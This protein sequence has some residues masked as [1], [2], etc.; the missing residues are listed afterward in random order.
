[1][2]KNKHQCQELWCIRLANSQAAL[3]AHKYEDVVNHSTECLD[4]L[5]ARLVLP[6]LSLRSVANEKR[7][8]LSKALEDAMQMI[9]CVPTSASGYLRAGS[10]HMTNGKPG[11]AADNFKQGLETVPKSHP[12]YNLLQYENGVAALR[13]RSRFDI[14]GKLP[15]ELLHKILVNAETE[16]VWTY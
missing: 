15:L 1:M 4:E 16:T 3:Y 8:L 9:Q 7:G 14:I 10:I 2:P 11:L 5:M 13:S 6:A 12:Q